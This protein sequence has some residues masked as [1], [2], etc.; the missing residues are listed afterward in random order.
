M[1]Q[2]AEYLIQILEKI[3]SPLMTAITAKV[4]DENG[5]ES[6]RT[7]AALLT[8]AVQ[9]SIDM[10]NATELAAV[11]AQ[12]DSLRVA[13]AA[14]AS[15][16]VASMFER[17]EEI[18]ED[19]DLKK[20]TTSLQAVLS[21]AENFAPNPENTQRL[22]DLAATGQA[23]DAHQV[24]IQYIQALTPVINACGAFSFGQSE[25]KVVME[26][27]SKL[28]ARSSNVRAAMF[29]DLPEGDQKMVELALLRTL[30]DVYAA[31]HD[32]ETQRLMTMS[33]ED[34]A[35][36]PQAPGGGLALDHVWKAFDLRVAMLE[37]LAENVLPSSLGGQAPAP[38][39]AAPVAPTEPPIAPVEQPAVATSP[40]TPPAAT[41]EPQAPPPPAQEQPATAPPAGANPMA[42]FA[43]P[44][45][46]SDETPPP[47]VPPAVTEAPPP[48]PASETPAAA[49]P[50]AT[51][52][53][54]T[55]PSEPTD[56]PEA[57]SSPMA[58][59]TQKPKNDDES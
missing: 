38:V 19:T 10:A 47:A 14:L 54:A 22:N 48:P 8:R 53:P 15:P 21:F 44:K 36:Q 56:A 26:I 57:E 9:A 5:E 16:L 20:I 46:D 28:V 52:P 27:T 58:F 40:P 45:T 55:P 1:D 6:A 39:A 49:T 24:N 25:Q 42:M 33:D 31:C 50:A 59:F 32:A 11:G 4:A 35:S 43:A 12:D 17:N 3:G 23:V 30:A 2:R 34:R 7:M 37:T 51:E 41:E 18:P 13:L 29:G